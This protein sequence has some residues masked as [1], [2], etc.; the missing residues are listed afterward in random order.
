M[1]VIHYIYLRKADNTRHKADGIF[2]DVNKA[3]KFIYSLRK[4]KTTHITGWT[5]E[6]AEDNE[7]LNQRI[8]LF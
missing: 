3:I 7:Y 1:I 2:F 8:N 4:N 6:N 5:C